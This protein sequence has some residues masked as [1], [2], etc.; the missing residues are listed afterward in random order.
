MQRIK[1]QMPLM[2]GEKTISSFYFNITFVVHGSVTKLEAIHCFR[3]TVILSNS[4]Q[5]K[6][7]ETLYTKHYSKVKKTLWEIQ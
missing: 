2:A 5:K 1:Y 6:V 3:N 4:V 7:S